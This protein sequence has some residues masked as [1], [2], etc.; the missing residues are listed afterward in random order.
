MI[1]G[2]ILDFDMTL[3]AIHAQHKGMGRRRSFRAAQA[4]GLKSY[5]LHHHSLINIQ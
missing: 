3:Q 2:D 4:Q 1:N 5:N